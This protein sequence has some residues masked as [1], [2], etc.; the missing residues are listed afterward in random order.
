M[1]VGAFIIPETSLNLAYSY[2][3]GEPMNAMARAIFFG[4][5]GIIHF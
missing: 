4:K 1:N 5:Y 3:K 2:Y